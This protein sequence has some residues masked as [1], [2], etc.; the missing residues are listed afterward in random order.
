MVVFDALCGPPINWTT[1]PPIFPLLHHHFRIDFHFYFF[2]LSD[3]SKYLCISWY[4]LWQCG[5]N[6]RELR[7]AFEMQLFT[8][9]LSSTPSEILSQILSW[10][11]PLSV[12]Q[13]ARVSRRFEAMI[14]SKAFAMVNLDRFVVKTAAN[15]SFNDVE[16]FCVTDLRNRELDVA[17]FRMPVTYQ[18]VYCTHFMKGRLEYSL[19]DDHG[20]NAE[21]VF[22]FSAISLE[23]GYANTL[24]VVSL[25]DCRLMGTIPHELGRLI[26]LE[27][28]N[29][30]DN[31]LAGEL[32]D[33]LFSG[34][35]KLKELDVSGNFLSGPLHESI[36]NLELLERLLCHNNRFEGPLPA[37]IGQLTQLRDF[38]A[39]NNR[40]FGTIPETVG[41]MESLVQLHLDNNSFCGVIPRELLNLKHLSEADLRANNQLTCTI[42]L[43]CLRW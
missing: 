28:L 41:D 20:S 31:A 7:T 9:P 25:A 12:L 13:Y 21:M 32:P 6:R 17:L 16:S 18:H 8:S 30:N 3:F 24:R 35:T 23:L 1:E 42:Y 5:G 2:F 19:F 40:F 11:H 22:H 34:L 15:L 14:F 27:N 29:L 38:Y 39:H 26:N 4:L 37:T 33:S 43:P 36:G 10:I